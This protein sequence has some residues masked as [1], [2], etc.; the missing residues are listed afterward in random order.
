MWRLSVLA[1]ALAACGA[2]KFGTVVTQVT[3]APTDTRVLLVRSCDL[4]YG[5][6]S[7]EEVSIGAC[8]NTSV[9]R[10]P[11][12]PVPLVD[13]SVIARDNRM[14]TGFV[15][16]P[17]GGAIVTTCRIGKEGDAWKMLDCVETP[18]ATAPLEAA[19]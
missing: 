14:V 5:K 7:V 17:N 19:P 18:I 4:E 3:V 13:A 9:R 11:I 1:L 15:E 10:S 2:T 6:Q 16:R 12:V 8:K